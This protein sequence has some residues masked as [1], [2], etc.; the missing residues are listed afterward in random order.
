MTIGA[1]Q[2]VQ[3]FW[4]DVWSGGKSDRV[5]ELF[6][7]NARQN[8]EPMDLE[9]F[10]AAVTTWKGTFPDFTATIEELVPLD[11]D[12]VLSRVTYRG[13]QR[14]RWAGL[15]PT[16]RSFTCVGIDIFRVVKGR[17]VEL[18]HATDHLDMASQLGAKVVLRP[19]VE[20]QLAKSSR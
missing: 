11:D 7:P 6:A 19:E 20:K 5:A 4:E 10:A 17:I 8:G 18:W 1:S 9:A 15:P 13:T 16:G 12:R 3:H 14:R 2:T